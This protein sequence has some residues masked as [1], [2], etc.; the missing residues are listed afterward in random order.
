[1]IRKIAADYKKNSI[2]ITNRFD[3]RKKKKAE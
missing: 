3:E 2:E 1:M